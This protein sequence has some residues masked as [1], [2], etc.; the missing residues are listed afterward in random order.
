MD[1][2]RLTDASSQHSLPGIVHFSFLPTL[3]LQPIRTISHRQKEKTVTFHLNF[4]CLLQKTVVFHLIFLCLLEKT[5]IFH[6]NF[7]CLLQKT[8]IF[9]R[10]YDCLLYFLVQTTLDSI[11][12][13]GEKL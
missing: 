6:S 8:V 13:K 5:V 2:S 3:L 1:N 7:Y 12:E 4:Y 11:V 9:Q 10:K